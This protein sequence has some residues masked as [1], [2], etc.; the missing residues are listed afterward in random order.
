MFPLGLF[1][2]VFHCPQGQKDI[3]LIFSSKVFKLL[4]FQVRALNHVECI[5]VNDVKERSHFIFFY[6]DN[7]LSQY[8][9]LKSLVFSTDL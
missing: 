9:L 1:K 2:E 6:V 8:Y 3:F 7:Q 5:C 4:L